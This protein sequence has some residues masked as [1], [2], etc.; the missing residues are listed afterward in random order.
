MTRTTTA[1]PTTATAA[2]PEPAWLAWL[3]R[4]VPRAAAPAARVA[5]LAGIVFGAAMVATSA[6]I[7]LHLW[8]IG[9]KHVHL[10]GPAF[11]FQAIS[12][13]VLALVMLGYRRLITVLAGLAF[14]AGSVVALLLSATVGFLGLHDGLSV[15]WAGWSLT[16]ELAGAVILF[17][18]AGVMLKRR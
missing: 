3:F 14:C 16:C 7:H 11:M 10:I 8:M 9:Y 4:P 6:V 12:G 18:C 2:A 15:P 13:F 1:A 5:V 17:G